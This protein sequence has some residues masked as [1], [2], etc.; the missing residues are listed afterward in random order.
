M[1]IDE[2]RWI[3]GWSDVILKSHTLLS[4]SMLQFH[5]HHHHHHHLIVVNYYLFMLFVNDVVSMNALKK[6]V[7]RMWVS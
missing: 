1:D 2:Y 5:H 7:Q 4:L 6:K 3:D